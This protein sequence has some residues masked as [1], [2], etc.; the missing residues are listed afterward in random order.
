MN[1]E[2]G[3]RADDVYTNIDVVNGQSGKEMAD[4]N[5]KRIHSSELPGTEINHEYISSHGHNST[6]L[7]TYCTFFMFSVDVS[8]VK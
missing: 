1:R 2:N 6:D 5:A 4:C 7:I 3:Q 8:G